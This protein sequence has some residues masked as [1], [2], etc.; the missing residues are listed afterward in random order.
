M[1]VVE[2]RYADEKYSRADLACEM[3]SSEINLKMRTAVGG[4]TRMTGNKFFAKKNWFFGIDV[5]LRRVLN[6]KYTLVRHP[7]QNTSTFFLDHVERGYGTRPVQNST[8]SFTFFNFFFIL[9][10]KR[11]MNETRKRVQ[12]LK[13]IMFENSG[14]LDVVWRPTKV[15]KQSSVVW[16]RVYFVL[17][18][19]FE[20]SAIRL[21]F[22][23]FSFFFTV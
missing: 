21:L 10:M 4:S 20:H 3:L 11:Q 2:S 22:F 19:L 17:L 9:L 14:H 12:R 7:N 23:F 8:S 18:R 5:D 6:K 1:H 16:Q 15:K 13:Y